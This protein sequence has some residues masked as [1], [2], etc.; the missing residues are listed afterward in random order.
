ME[1]CEFLNSDLFGHSKGGKILTNKF[2]QN[3]IS[4]IGTKVI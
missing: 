3:N 2:F 4:Y 1:M